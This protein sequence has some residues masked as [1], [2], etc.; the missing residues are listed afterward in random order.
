VL[1]GRAPFA[2]SPDIGATESARHPDPLPQRAMIISSEAAS[3]RTMTRQLRS[4]PGLRE[5]ALDERA[6]VA[7]MARRGWMAAAERYT[8]LSK[9]SQRSGCTKLAKRFARAIG[10]CERRAGAYERALA[11]IA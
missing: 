8:E 9:A 2:D 7:G 4:L 3:T 6:L 1:A 11:R 10:A 5:V